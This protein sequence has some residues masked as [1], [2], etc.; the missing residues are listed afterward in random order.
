V[1]SGNTK[2]MN[3]DNV[4]SLATDLSILL[5][6]DLSKKILKLNNNNNLV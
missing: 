6:A 3:I 2:L 1:T 4:H 5:I